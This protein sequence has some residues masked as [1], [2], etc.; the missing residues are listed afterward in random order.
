MALVNKIIPFSC[1]DGPGNRMVIFF[2]GCNFQCL[3]CHN[4]ETINKCIAC[5]KCVENC[6]VGA[7][8]I[9]DGKVIW[10][11]EECIACDKC[12]KIC[13]HMSSPKIKDY[14]V[15]E[16]I[17]K[18]EN[19]RFFIRGITVSG[20]ECTLNSDFLI[21]LFKEVKKMGLTCF[22]DTNGNTELNH[23]LMELTDKFMLD[24]KSIDEEE[25]IWLTKSSNK[26]VLENLKR[27]LDLN[28]MYEVRTVIAPGLDSEKTV[29]AVSKIIGDKCRYKLIK[30]RQFGV[31][32]EGIEAHGR[33]SPRD[34]YMNQLKD[35]SIS[36]GC[37]DTIIT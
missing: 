15:E 35:K 37:K 32:E 11:E 24:V 29:D 25:S 18:I 1:V 3:Y 6:E 31:R 36:N 2:Q 26:L 8:S 20:G 30:Y 33:I 28:K 19:D 16:L 23:E 21:K 4:P 10:D 9:K 27:I 5:G 34:D 14:S 17:K 7:L 12:I 13:E 22:V